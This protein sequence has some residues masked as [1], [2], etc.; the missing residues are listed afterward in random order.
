MPATIGGRLFKS[1]KDAKKEYGRIRDNG[2]RA[3]ADRVEPRF[4]ICIG[5]AWN[6]P[7]TNARLIQGSRRHLITKAL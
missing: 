4:A 5:T 2:I 6:R 3:D 1:K 7:R